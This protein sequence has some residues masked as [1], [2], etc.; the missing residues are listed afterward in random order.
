MLQG[1]QWGLWRLGKDQAA[2]EVMLRPDHSKWA[3]PPRILC[4]THL[5][6]PPCP[7]SDP[8]QTWLSVPAL[9]KAS[10]RTLRTGLC[11]SPVF[12]APDPALSFGVPKV[13]NKKK[14]RLFKAR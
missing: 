11:P 4:P 2:Q 12:P 9:P 7:S 1:E 10:P 8:L 3:H 6:P 5:G 13:K 14:T